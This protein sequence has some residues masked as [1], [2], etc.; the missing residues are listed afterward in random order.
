MPPWTE[1]ATAL[2]AGPFLW[3]AGAVF[4]DFVHWVLHVMLRSRWSVLRA[5]AWPHQVHHEWIDTRLEIHWEYQNK[6]IWC[7]LV[8]EYLTQVFFSATLLLLLAPRFVIVLLALQTAVFLFLLR[9]KGLDLN[10]RPIDYLDAYGPG[11]HTPPAYH[12]LHHVYPNAY[13]SAY[14]KVVDWLVAGGAQLTGRSYALA[15]GTK[16]LA[17]AFR[18][19]LARFE[20]DH[21]ADWNSM[22]AAE[23]EGLDVLV[24]CG[25]DVVAAVES[26]IAATANRK[27]PPEV[28]SLHDR[29]DDPIAR[30]YHRDVRVNYRTIVLPEATTLDPQRIRAAI[31]TT[32]AGIRRGFNFVP[33]EISAS[34]ITNWLRFER[35]IPD[36]PDGLS[37]VAHRADLVH[38]GSS[39]PA[40]TA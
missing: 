3:F 34:V 24:L 33:S 35:T 31:R 12:A 1:I 36:V 27:L 28:W 8:L 26:F 2:V 21:V 23:R 14:T 6:N 38:P 32:F 20:V 10:H 7:H 17:D 16:A 5:I 37:D 15:G 13:Y 11:F 39:L 25:G 30:H 9:H 40:A 29:P 18:S 22:S 4:F 19:E